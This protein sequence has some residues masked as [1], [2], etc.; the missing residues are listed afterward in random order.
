MA[1][2][3]EGDRVD[4]IA[5]AAAA[6]ISGLRWISDVCCR[7]SSPRAP[8]G[9]A[10]CLTFRTPLISTCRPTWHKTPLSAESSILSV[11]AAYFLTPVR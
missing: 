9:H 2:R 3:G 11:D 8:S 4:P 5:R 1:R 10:G 7:H 6:W